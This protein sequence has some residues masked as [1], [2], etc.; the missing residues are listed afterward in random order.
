MNNEINVEETILSAKKSESLTIA[1]ISAAIDQATAAAASRDVIKKNPDEV[2]A[3]IYRIVLGH[4]V[5]RS[6]DIGELTI[7]IQDQKSCD[8]NN[9]NLWVANKMQ[10]AT[11][12]QIN[13]FTTRMNCAIS[14]V[15]VKKG[16]VDLSNLP[17]FPPIEDEDREDYAERKSMAITERQKFIDSMHFS[18]IRLIIDEA[19]NLNHYIQAIIGPEVVANF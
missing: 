4:H 7:T 13:A 18:V 19:I 2:N 6:F 15:S 16:D 8:I 1:D 14:L 9:I 12:E 5:Y 10:G 3:D 11:P 17:P